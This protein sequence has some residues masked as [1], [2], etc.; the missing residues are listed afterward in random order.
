MSNISNAGH[1]T[2][3]LTGLA[4]LTAIIIVLQIVC[5]FIHFGPFSITLALAPIIIGA[6]IY[7]IGAGVYLGTVFGTIVLIAGL[8]SWDGG[9]TLIL[10][11]D[12]ALA[13]IAICIVKGAAAGLAAGILYRLISKKNVTA[14]VI[15][16]GVVCPIVNTGLFIVGMLVFFFPMLKGMAQE[17]SQELTY[18]II[19]TLTG[20]N[21]LV[22]LAVN[23]L[24]STAITR[25]IKAKNRIF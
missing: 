2:R 7:G 3:R 16:A 8:F 24:F 6:A 1:K 20:L 23:M 17:E 10:L 18:Y 4:F 9:F 14:G 22:E 12:N 21:F 5:S 19:F 13:T 25:I 11:N 15:T